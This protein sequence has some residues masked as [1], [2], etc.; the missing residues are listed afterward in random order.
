[1]LKVT[2]ASPEKQFF[3]QEADSV[4]L[5][6]VSGEFEVLKGHAAMLSVLTT[7]CVYIKAK[8]SNEA[9]YIDSGI[10]EISR[11]QVSIL[12]DS[13]HLARVSEQE[14][15]EHQQRQCRRG[16]QSQ[17]NINYQEL[18]LELSRLNAE[19]KTIKRIKSRGKRNDI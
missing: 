2:I 11:N 14:Q 1:M 10:V 5:P 6:G 7:G 19:L 3:N 16:L 9:V 13:A 8:D 4:V 12:V 18:M 15:L 17:D